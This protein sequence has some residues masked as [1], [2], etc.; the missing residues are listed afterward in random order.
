M[1]HRGVG[2]LASRPDSA[3]SRTLKDLSFEVA[4]YAGFGFVRFNPDVNFLG[5]IDPGSL[6]P[7]AKWEYFDAHIDRCRR[8]GLEI[9]LTL[10]KPP[11]SGDNALWI[12]E[13]NGTIFEWD[14]TDEP[15]VSF[16]YQQVLNRLINVLK[17]PESRVYVEI[18]NEASRR[19]FGGT[20]V[21]FDTGEIQPAYVSSLDVILD[22]LRRAF[23]RVTYLSPAMSFTDFTASMDNPWTTEI[24]FLVP[25]AM[26]SPP[27]CFNNADI[28][29]LHIY[30]D[31]QKYNHILTWD[32]YRSWVVSLLDD[33]IA[34][35]QSKG[36]IGESILQKPIWITEH[37]TSFTNAGMEVSAFKWGNEIEL[38]LFRAAAFEA[39]CR[40]PKVGA[41]F[42]Y[43]A[44]N[45]ESGDDVRAGMGVNN[46]GLLRH[47][48]SYTQSYKIMAAAHG[49]PNP[50][51]PAGSLPAA[52]FSIS[53]Y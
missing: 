46:Y 38:A 18:A 36:A 42:Y 5:E 47:D 19:A 13:D 22:N 20:G 51:I 23:P 30:S 14:N 2:V 11:N 41:C 16:L 53:G 6:V 17:W 9:L 27:A 40:H 35:W 26:T 50:A 52:D 21:G 43:N 39:L 15:G 45:E 25:T 34:Y 48:T 8:H 28:L 1:T 37:G 33:F 7:D 44:I 32:D 29:N 31:R 4:K 12:S 49:I 3:V 10:A 24:D